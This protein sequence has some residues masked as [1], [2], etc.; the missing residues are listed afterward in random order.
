MNKKMVFLIFV[1]III[2]CFFYKSSDI[3][4]DKIPYLDGVPNT[5]STSLESKFLLQW[6]FPIFF[7]LLFFSGMIKNE[8]ST[9]GIAFITRYRNKTYWLIKKLIL[10]WIITFSFVL[11]QMLLYTF[12]SFEIINNNYVIL[13]FLYYL[14]LVLLVNVQAM[15]ELYV[16]PNI[17]FILVNIYV[18]ASV[19]IHNMVYKYVNNME[20]LFIVPGTMGLRNGLTNSELT[21]GSYN[22]SIIIIMLIQIIACSFIC[23]KRIKK[24][25]IV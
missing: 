25:D 18:I 12:G 3:K 7:I 14:L 21:Q 1:S 8:L 10:L 4:M 11:F 17:A 2:Q 13:L 22:S 5:S 9:S 6:Y 19:L 20:Y 24:I 23:F 16:A 15:L